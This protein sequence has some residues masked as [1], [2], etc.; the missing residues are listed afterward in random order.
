M[1]FEGHVPDH[2]GQLPVMEME[3]EA[4]EELAIKEAERILEELKERYSLSK[5]LCVHRIGVLKVGDLAIWIGT[6]SQQP[7]E[8][9]WAAAQALDAIKKH[10]P[11][12]K[13]EW[14]GDGRNEW[15]S[16]NRSESYSR[17]LKSS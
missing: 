16:G 1:V 5:I 12:W 11:I 9:F 14:S 7:R 6:V 8:A 2:E 10:V 17:T 15:I 3:Y 13:K 4:Y